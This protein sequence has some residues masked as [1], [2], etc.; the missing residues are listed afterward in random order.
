MAP[1]LQAQPAWLPAA[2]YQTTGT[3]SLHFQ[4]AFTPQ[5][6]QAALAH[7][8]TITAGIHAERRFM[9]NAMNTYTA[10]VAVPI[11]T[12]TFGLTAQQYGFTAY[13]EQKIALAYGRRLGTK[14]SIGLQLDYLS[15][16]IPTYGAASTV[17]AEAGILFHINNSWHAGLHTINPA[18]QQ[19][20][21][22]REPLP[23]IWSAGI[24]YEASRNCLLSAEVVKEQTQPLNARAMLEYRIVQP[25]AIM[26][27]ISTTPQL[28][29]AAVDCS[30]ESL[31]LRISASYHPILGI[32]PG[33]TIIWQQKRKIA[34]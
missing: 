5:Q 1:A 12:G 13:K 19:I 23:S 34:G 16:S 8:T 4:H 33:L 18:A 9:I 28:N 14:I 22:T 30:W 20:G 7:I 15:R 31:R 32:T 10:T 3:Y 26:L 27:G 6:N 29:T 11:S 21:A 25:L 17:T 24:G 2:K